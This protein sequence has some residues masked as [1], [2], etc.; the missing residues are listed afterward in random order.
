MSKKSRARSK[1]RRASMRRARKAASQ[2]QY[3]TWAAQ[4]TNQKS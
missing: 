2:L 1:D 3:A 4:G